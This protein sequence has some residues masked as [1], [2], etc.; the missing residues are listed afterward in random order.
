[1]VTALHDKLSTMQSRLLNSHTH[2]R[3]ERTRGSQRLVDFKFSCFNYKLLS[4]VIFRVHDLD[5]L[6]LLEELGSGGFGVVYR[7]TYHGIEVAVKVWTAA[8]PHYKHMRHDDIWSR[9]VNR[10]FLSS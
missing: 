7:G 10:V 8:P 6:D 3:C 5:G 2:D 1:M 4:C 9:I